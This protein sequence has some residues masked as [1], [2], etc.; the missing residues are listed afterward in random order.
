MKKTL[1]LIA[2]LA[3]NINISAK[4]QDQSELATIANAATKFL[5]LS[6]Q[7]KWLEAKPIMQRAYELGQTIY[8]DSDPSFG[9]IAYHYGSVLAALKEPSAL[10]PLTLALNNY[11][12]HLG[13]NSAEL[14]PLLGDLASAY[15]LS[16]NVDQAK[17]NI[18]RALKLASSEY[19]KDSTM[20]ANLGSRAGREFATTGNY[21]LALRLQNRAY[22]IYLNVFGATSTKTGKAAYDISESLR[23][24]NSILRQIRFLKETISTFDKSNKAESD[25]E[26]Q[27]HTKLVQAYH[28]IGKPKRATP[29]VL[30]LANSSTYT[31]TQAPV[32]LV[33]TNASDLGRRANKNLQGF[34]SLKF[35]VDSKGYTRNPRLIE[36]EGD[37]KLIDLAIDTLSAYR[38]I[39]EVS[40]GEPIEANDMETKIIF[41]WDT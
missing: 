5:V 3:S 41:K 7:E 33:K 11:E 22:E 9:P 19:G 12:Q 39:P 10:V 21:K 35:D 13:D 28:A 26:R 37:Q 24:N 20:V 18:T 1:V 31:D 16:G 38:Y 40:N 27:V 25:F 34:V 17:L 6:S 23:L 32:L 15:T 14:I 8:Q 30:A 29:H 36:L 2:L 4:A